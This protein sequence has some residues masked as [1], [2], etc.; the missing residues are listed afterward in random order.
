[1][2]LSSAYG[3]RVTYL[4]VDRVPTSL[5]LHTNLPSCGDLLEL[6]ECIVARDEL[7]ISVYFLLLKLSVQFRSKWL[8]EDLPGRSS[9]AL[10]FQARRMVPKHRS[11]D[12]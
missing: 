3:V 10:Y 6:L 11:R 12:A 7:G 9:E 5:F 1:M 2:V 4:Q 8:M